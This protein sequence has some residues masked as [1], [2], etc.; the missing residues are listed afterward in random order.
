[1]TKKTLQPK[2]GIHKIFMKSLR[3]CKFN[4]QYKPEEKIKQKLEQASKHI[5]ERLLIW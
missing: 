4:T 1:M 5:Y 3:W 2:K